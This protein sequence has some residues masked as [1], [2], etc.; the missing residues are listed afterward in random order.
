M[1]RQWEEHHFRVVFAR[2]LPEQIGSQAVL[3]FGSLCAVCLLVV[4]IHQIPSCRPPRRPMIL[5][6]LQV[7]F[8]SVSGSF[9]NAKAASFVIVKS[10]K[11]VVEAQFPRH[12]TTKEANQP[13]FVRTPFATFTPDRRMPSSTTMNRCDAR[14]HGVHYHHHL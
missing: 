11:A 14:A 13:S 8:I 10:A 3:S 9:F 1:L 5:L 4:P 6:F 2:C 7:F 12:Q